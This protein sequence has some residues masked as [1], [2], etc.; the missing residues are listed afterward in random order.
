MPEQS[1]DNDSIKHRLRGIWAQILHEDPSFFSDEDVFFEVGGNSILAQNLVTAAQKQGIRLTVP[2]I[3]M[4]ASLEEMADIAHVLDISEEDAVNRASTLKPFGLW[5]EDS[6]LHDK[7]EAIATKCKVPSSRIETAYPCSP[8][9]ESLVAE[10]DESRNLYVRQFVF[11][12]ANDV[13]LDRFHQAWQDTIRA[14]PV[15]RTRICQLEG[16]LGYLQAVIDEVALWSTVDYD[17]AKFL[18]RDA[19]DHMLLGEPYFRYTIVVGEGSKREL[20]RHFIWTVHHALCDGASIPEILSDVSRRFRD[21]PTLQRLSFEAFIQSSAIMPDPWQEQQFWKRYL[22]ELSPTPYPP[23]FQAPEFQAVPSSTLERSLTLERVPSFFLTKALLLRT[24]WAILLSH[25]SGSED[26]GFGAINSGRTSPV[27]GVSQLTGPTI[28]LVPIVLRIDPEQSVASFSSQI[29][30][31]ATEMTQFEHSG[32]SRIRNYLAGGDTTAADFQTLLV[33]DPMA[34]SDA[35]APA[36]RI[37]GLEYVDGLGK[38]EQHPYPLIV[39]FTISTDTIVTIKLQ[40]D[41]RIF[42]D[43]Q[44]YNLVNH[45]QTVL[46][47]LGSATDDTL[48][49]SISPL[50]DHD[51]AQI[52]D[53]NKSTPLAEKTCIHHL[54][55]RQV[56]KQP[57]AVA[58]CSREQSLSYTEIDDYSSSLAVHLIE[59]GV[60]PGAFLGVCFEKSI[61]IVIA[62]LAVFKAGGVYVP[63][64]PAHPRG[65]IVEI[66]KTVQ[67]EVAIASKASAGVLDGLCTQIITVHDRPPSVSWV[68]PPSM[69]LP[70]S[71]AYLLFTSGST[72]KPKGI[73][74]SHSAICTSIVHHGAAFGAGSHW[75]TLQFGPHTFDLS[76]AEFFTTLCFGG[77]ICVPSDYDRQNNLADAI[78]SLNANTLLVVPTVANVLFPKDVPTLTTIVLAGEPITKETVARWADHV[79]LTDAYGPSETAVYCSGNVKVTAEANPAHIGR[80]IGATMWIVSP[81]NYQRL[82]AIGCVGEIVISGA[83]LGEGYFKDKATTDAAFLPAPEWMQLFNPTSPYK[84]IYRSGDLARYNPDGT[85]HIVGRRDT[86]VKL[87]GF[88]IELGEIENQM[89]AHGT[90]TAALAALPTKGPCA[91]QIVVVVSFNQSDLENHSN[92]KIVILRGR[93]PMKTKKML[94]KLRLHVSLTLPEYMIPSIW[95]PL[96]KMPL[97]ISGKIDRKTIKLWIDDMSNETY[98]DLVDDQDTKEETEITPGSLADR[99]RQLWSEVLSVPKERIGTR[100]SFF[101]LGGDSIAAI[102]VVSHAKETGLPVSVRGIISTRTL[103]NLVN[104]IEQSQMTTPRRRETLGSSQYT[105]DILLP[106]EHILKWSLKE[107]TSAKLE[108]AYPLSPFQREIMKQ[109]AI[110]PAIFLLS[111]QMEISSRTPHALSLSRLVRSWECVV[112]KYPILRTIFLQDPTG[113]LPALQVVLAHA[114]PEVATSSALAGEMEPTFDTTGL[115]DVDNCFLPHR[116]HFSQYGD[117]FFIHIEL[118]HLVIDGWSLKLIKTAFLD[119]IETEETCVPEEPPSYKAFVAAHRPDRV[120]TDDKYWVS[121]LRNQRPALLF[122]PVDSNNTQPQPSYNR[123]IIYLPAVKAQA[124]TTFSVQNGITAASIFDAAWSQTLSLY[125]HSADVTFE[126]VV[127]GRDEDVS[128]IFDMVGPLINV[129]A[130]HLHDITTENNSLEL[131]RIAQQMQ[132]Q[133]AQ[134]SLHSSSNVREVIEKTLDAGKLFNTAVNFQRRPSAVETKNL[135]IDDNLKKS[136]DPWH[137]CCCFLLLCFSFTLFWRR[138]II[139]DSFP[140]I[141]R[142]LG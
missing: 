3:F 130:Y 84:M 90:I 126:Y 58:V 86:Q 42:S 133:R 9:Q 138:D 73:L 121:V 50:S 22:S 81:N 5:I 120:D 104:L 93:Q 82:S 23:P 103:G 15:L 95:I 35:I 72:G 48:L 44:A 70:S 80:S 16:T 123:D 85:F 45:F 87:R 117:K 47:Q 114:E 1:I 76:I 29:R 71:T 49:G 112:R 136:S 27:P 67:I 43:Q 14:N 64:D 69:S 4:H 98:N 74:M 110:N 56:L 63:I 127:S 34:F 131:A 94:E 107:K 31:H 24:A 18:E 39:T 54:F 79:D 137:V 106:Y 100:T 38:K 122:L 32:I 33:V 89:M 111:W 57:D 65:R 101:A 78:T 140:Q 129:L 135:R 99:V 62:I 108:D 109:R 2:Q 116:A 96:E 6:S 40:H 21:E 118:N 25:Y 119:A 30:A 91:R 66:V 102:Q 19:R 105:D 128:G 46:T 75:R 37:L 7:I 139:D 10:F 88:R 142:C 41:D 59:L 55:H 28:N 132:E 61:W 60:R 115:P 124:L 52:R 12:L 83:L 36:L 92:S 51:V 20:R 97:L 141:V 68:D 53:W 17:L 8:M 134:D 26:V 125:T 77:C 13:S 11:E 113:Q